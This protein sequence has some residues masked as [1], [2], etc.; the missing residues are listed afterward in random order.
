[1]DKTVKKVQFEGEV[2]ISALQLLFMDRFSY[3]SGQQDFPHIYIHDTTANISYELE[4]VS[5]VQDKS[6]LSLDL[7]C[8]LQK[9]R[10][11]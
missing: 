2:T 5:D 8:K 7:E 1:M 9:Y 11:I 6:V 10:L 4:D 3:T